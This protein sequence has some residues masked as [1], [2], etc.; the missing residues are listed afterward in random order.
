MGR[1][2][3]RSGRATRFLI[4]GTTVAVVGAGTAVAVV[5]TR[6]GSP[7][8]TATAP[9]GGGGA[10]SGG[11]GGSASG[12]GSPP[13]PPVTISSGPCEAT[14]C[15]TS[16][17]SASFTFSALGASA[18]ECSLDGG[19][20]SSCTS[21]HAVR[22]LSTGRHVFRARV[23]G[24]A[25]TAGTFAWTVSLDA[26]VSSTSASNG[27]TQHSSGHAC[28]GPHG[29]W[30]YT[31]SFRGSSVSARY[32]LRW[33]FA[34]GSNS[35]PIS[36]TAHISPISGVRIH[37]TIHD[38]VLKATASGHGFTGTATAHLTARLAGTR[39]APVLKFVQAS[40]HGLVAG[41]GAASPF[42][43]PGAALSLP[44][45]LRAFPGCP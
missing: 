31:L 45:H 30:T 36:G 23:A 19:A 7:N 9:G 13:P 11:Q 3:V 4:I 21:P 38:G 34:P 42:G 44:I 26:V 35:A 37:V 39:R 5:L 2:G 17:T 6:S 29:H 10:A 18:F 27:V 41:L 16:A 24:A 12:G 32:D 15:T 14:G 25:Q 20:F 8:A 22:G 28:G 43:S 40:V 1:A 33:T